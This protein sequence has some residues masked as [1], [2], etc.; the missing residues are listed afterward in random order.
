[1]QVSVETTNGLER[2]MTVTVPAERI[3]K[4]VAT[5]LQSLSRSVKM[6]GF[7]PGKVPLKVVTS[8][9]GTQVHNEVVSEV[10]RSTFQEAVT[11]ENIKLVGTPNI[12]SVSIESGKDLEYVAT[13]EV[14]GEVELVA[15]DSL[16]IEKPIAEITDQDFDTVIET[17]RKQHATWEDVERPAEKDDRLIIDFEGTVD[18][19]PFDGNSGQQ[20]P[21]ILGSESYISGFEDQLVGVKA[22][23]DVTLSL[24]FPDSYRVT[25]LAGK[26]VEFQVKVHTVSK[27]ILPE[28]D[29]EFMNLFEVKDSDKE[30]FFSDVRDNMSKELEQALKE[31]LKQNVLSTLYEKNPVD[32]PTALVNSTID[33]MMAQLTSNGASQAGDISALLQDR[34]AFS[35]PAKRKVSLGMLVGDIARKNDFKPQMEQVRTLIDSIAENYDDPEEVT[36]WYL[37][38]QNRL[39]NIETLIV[40]DMVVDWVM[41]Q[42][43]VNEKTYSFDEIMKSRQSA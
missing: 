18:G 8:R 17:L 32:V 35:E 42:A 38:D 10:T 27:T 31:K 24:T 26:Q 1:M 43:A 30:T 21:L 9:Y 19:E 41:E 29:A 20:T 23:E 28:I 7:R 6:S 36:R 37:S 5:R 34:G 13:F 39:A 16:Q 12:E 40:E 33:D 25:E 22:G 2:R 4:E 15:M 3:E 11:N 14:L